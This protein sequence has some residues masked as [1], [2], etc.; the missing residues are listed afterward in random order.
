MYIEYFE[1]KIKWGIRHMVAWKPKDDV[2]LVTD[3]VDAL[4]EL[5]AD[6]QC[7]F[8]SDEETI[9]R[10]LNTK[11]TAPLTRRLLRWRDFAWRK[12]F[13]AIG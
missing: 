2:Y 3:F 13:E 11:A 7:C 6:N 10:L 4:D 12:Y 1:N 5:V 9:E 8:E